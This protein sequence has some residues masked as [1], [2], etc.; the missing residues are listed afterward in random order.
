MNLVIVR[1]TDRS[2]SRNRRHLT[3]EPLEAHVIDQERVEK[4]RSTLNVDLQ[5]LKIIPI[6]GIDEDAE[7]DPSIG[8]PFHIVIT[9]HEPNIAVVLLPGLQLNER[10]GDQGCPVAVETVAEDVQDPNVH[11]EL[12]P[13]VA[14]QAFARQHRRHPLR[15]GI[16]A[17]NPGGPVAGNQGIVVHGR[18]D[19]DPAPRKDVVGGGLEIRVVDQVSGAGIVW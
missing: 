5:K 15:P 11:L 3:G 14:G 4:I 9:V 7:V 2:R 12:P 16:P 8:P 10:T 6:F 13:G 17:V 19:D 18:R 1:T